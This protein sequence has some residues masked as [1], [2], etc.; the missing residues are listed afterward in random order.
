MQVS[1]A[2]RTAKTYIAELFA[3]EKIIEIGLEEVRIDDGIWEI[4]IG[5]RRPWP[6]RIR[7]ET[8]HG[9]EFFKPKYKFQDRWYKVVRI[10]DADGIVLGVDDRELFAA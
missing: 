3:D 10:R 8:D 1:E 9:L 5:F 2:V 4:T 6:K 7:A